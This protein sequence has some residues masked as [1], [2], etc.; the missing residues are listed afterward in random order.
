MSGTTRASSRCL[1]YLLRIYGLPSAER[2]AAGDLFTCRRTALA[3]GCRP[4]PRW[5]RSA[6]ICSR[7]TASDRS[8]EETVMDSLPIGEY[9]LLSDC[10]SAA[11]VS[12]DGSVDWLCFPRFD[13]PSVFCRL[14]DPAGGHFAV[15]PAGE[16]QVSRRSP[17]GAAPTGCSCQRCRPARRGGRPPQ[18]R[19]DRQ[20]PAGVQS[21]RPD[22][23]RLGHHPSPAAHRARRAIGAAPRPSRV[24]I[25]TI[26]LFA[27]HPVG[28]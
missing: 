19:D 24:E 1:D 11:L 7:R 15:R 26:R 20:L 10:R 28:V 18:R 13:G 22:Q 27:G 23:R 16:F 9:A 5:V 12:R 2:S 6:R 4:S 21:H 3:R 25:R 14:L 8:R 17:P